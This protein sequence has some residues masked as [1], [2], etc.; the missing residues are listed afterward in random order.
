MGTDSRR[1]CYPELVREQNG[2][3]R[4]MFFPPGGG[5]PTGGR[6]LSLQ[7]VGGELSVSECKSEARGLVLEVSEVTIEP[8]HPLTWQ[9]AGQRLRLCDD[10]SVSVE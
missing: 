2:T 9:V 8:L 10:T 3:G 1:V 6:N 5:K 7:P 4:S